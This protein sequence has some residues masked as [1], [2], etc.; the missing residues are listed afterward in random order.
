VGHT[1]YL[2][3]R[4][5]ALRRAQRERAAQQRLHL[6]DV[7]VRAVV[8]RG[9]QPDQRA[10]FEQR[11]TP[12]HT[13]SLRRRRGVLEQVDEYGSFVT[14]QVVPGEERCILVG[15]GL[16][17][18]GSCAYMASSPGAYGVNCRLHRISGP[19]QLGGRV[20]TPSRHIAPT[21][22][23]SNRATTWSHSGVV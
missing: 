11:V 18:L 16:D 23:Y 17:E 10:Q 6:V 7:V 5:H 9:Q 12:G 4:P 22:C 2:G 1:I 3:R 20:N 14:V 21:V 13:T 19:T 15:R 8:Q